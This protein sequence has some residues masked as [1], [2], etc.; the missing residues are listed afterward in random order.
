MVLDQITG[1]LQHNPGDQHKTMKSLI[2]ILQVSR[3]ATLDQP[4]RRPLLTV[5]RLVMR[6]LVRDELDSLLDRPRSKAK[7]CEATELLLKSGVAR[8]SEYTTKEE[9]HQLDME[10]PTNDVHMMNAESSKRVDEDFS[11]ASP[12]QRAAFAG[13]EK[14]VL[15]LLKYGADI[16]SCPKHGLTALD[17][18]AGMGRMDTLD[19]LL[20]SGAKKK[21]VRAAEMKGFHGI[22]TKISSFPITK[23]GI[24][25]EIEQ[26]YVRYKETSIIIAQAAGTERKYMERMEIDGGED[27]SNS[28]EY[29]SES[30]FGI[31]PS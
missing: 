11:M 27:V 2:S 8:F 10:L 28:S 23:D 21:R 30:P 15:L 24:Q 25:K 9:S 20:K 22:G 6:T 14:M 12:L 26:D 19:I 5:M 1:Y 13:N 31:L 3:S 17:R 29:V 7:D 4:S 16:D 18:A